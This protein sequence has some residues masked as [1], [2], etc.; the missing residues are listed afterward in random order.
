M[1][2]LSSN[3]K[4]FNSNL[5][6]ETRNVTL[7]EKINAMTMCKYVAEHEGGLPEFLFSYRNIYLDRQPANNKLRAP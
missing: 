4:Y 6:N 7:I 5:N 1:C 3:S 2:N